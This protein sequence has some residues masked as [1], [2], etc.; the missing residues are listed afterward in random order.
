MTVI[1]DCLKLFHGINEGIWLHLSYQYYHQNLILHFFKLTMI[2]T[3]MD[4]Y[5]SQ[6]SY[7]RRICCED[8]LF[9]QMTSLKESMNNQQHQN[10]RFPERWSSA[11]NI[12]K[13]P[14]TVHLYIVKY[15]EYKYKIIVYIIVTKIF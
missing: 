1:M 7:N 11:E 14:N 3:L 9:P 6:Y 15:N 5:T 13:C 2:I 8:D 10:N 4:L 12:R